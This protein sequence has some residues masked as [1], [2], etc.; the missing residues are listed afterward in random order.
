MCGRL[1]ARRQDDRDQRRILGDGIRRQ[2]HGQRRRKIATRTLK[3]ATAKRR[4]EVRSRAYS[5]L[6][7][8]SSG[9]SSANRWIVARG[10]PT[11][12]GNS[13]RRGFIQINGIPA[14]PAPRRSY[15][16][17][18]P[19]NSDSAGSDPHALQRQHEDRRVGLGDADL[20]RD[21]QQIQVF[22]QPETARSSAAAFGPAHWSPAQAY[23]MAAALEAY[24]ARHPRA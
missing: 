21:D 20:F 24:A 7:T 23:S 14:A 4:Q 5:W 16:G 12:L 18:S 3:I 9:G 15:S 1:V 6:I 10:G 13:S 8:S 17:E 11:P 19:T 2:Q 22:H